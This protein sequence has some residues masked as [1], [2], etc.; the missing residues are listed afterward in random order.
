M[1]SII[2]IKGRRWSFSNG[3][4]R[5]LLWRLAGMIGHRGDLHNETDAYNQLHWLMTARHF[6]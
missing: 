4:P 1:T 3:Y 6:L 2:Q 5:H